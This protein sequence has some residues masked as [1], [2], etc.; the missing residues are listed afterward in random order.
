MNLHQSGAYSELLAIG[1]GCFF[2]LRAFA[3]LKAGDAYRGKVKSA[4]P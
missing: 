3:V 4:K 1:P 2:V